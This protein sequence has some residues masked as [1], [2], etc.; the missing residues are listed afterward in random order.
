ML[1]KQGILTEEEKREEEH[2]RRTDRD[3]WRMWMPELDNGKI[4]PG[5]DIHSLWRQP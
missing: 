3:F 1:A 5:E 4:E 2:Y